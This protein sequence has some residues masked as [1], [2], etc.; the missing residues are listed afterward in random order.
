MLE[1]QWKGIVWP[2]SVEAEF[3]PETGVGRERLVKVGRA[4]VDVPEGFVSV[5]FVYVRCG[6][7][8]IDVGDA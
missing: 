2:A 5:I 3:D 4:S 6:C 7:G 8:L 1:G